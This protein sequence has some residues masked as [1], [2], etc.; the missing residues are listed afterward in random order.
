MNI[1]GV[2]L[3][4]AGRHD[5]AVTTFTEAITLDPNYAAAYFNRSRA[6]RAL[7]KEKEAEAELEVW[8]ARAT[9]AGAEPGAA[10]KE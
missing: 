4:E 3:L 7:G 5:E 8:R 6:Y 2:R 1:D 9:G 10:A